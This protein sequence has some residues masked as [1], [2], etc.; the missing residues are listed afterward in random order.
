MIQ[1]SIMSI[2][3]YEKDFFVSNEVIVQF[4]DIFV[5]KLFVNGNLF[6]YHFNISIAALKRNLIKNTIF[7]A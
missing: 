7:M 5:E 1:I 4:D 2:F 3:H 6:F